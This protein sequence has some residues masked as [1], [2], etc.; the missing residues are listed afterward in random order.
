MFQGIKNTANMLSNANKMKA[1]QAKMQAILDSVVVTGS[2]K[3]SKVTARVSGS[4]KILDLKIE[5][6]LITF[7]QE[8]FIAEGK[9]DT[10]LAKSIME[11]IDDAITKVQPEVIKKMQESGSLGDLMSM[12][13]G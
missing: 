1:Q 11:A 8:N 5:P 13:Q 12:L 10:L 2:S 6:A 9:E 3:N 4:Q 7:V